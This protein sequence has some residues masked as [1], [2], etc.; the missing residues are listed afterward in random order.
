VA[1]IAEAIQIPSSCEEV[2]SNWRWFG[3]PSWIVE[4]FSVWVASCYKMFSAT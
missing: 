1:W 2:V 3:S 4:I